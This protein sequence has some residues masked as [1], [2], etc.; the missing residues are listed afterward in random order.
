MLSLLLPTQHLVVLR[1]DGQGSPTATASDADSGG[2]VA[3]AFFARGRSLG[4]VDVGVDLDRDEDLGLRESSLN[5]AKSM[6]AVQ[7]LNVTKS[8]NCGC[9]A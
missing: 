8:L 2:H 3:E 1:P 7:S 4:G 9:R 5:G 6:D